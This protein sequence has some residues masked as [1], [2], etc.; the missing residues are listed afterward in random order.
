MVRAFNVTCIQCN[1][2]GDFARQNKL[3]QVTRRRCAAYFQRTAPW[4]RAP[5]CVL[6]DRYSE[7]EM[8]SPPQSLR[9]LLPEYSPLVPSTI[10]R[11]RRQVQ[12][13]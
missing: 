2:Y 10:M 6:G 3:N 13:V 9:R 8:R 5:L 7:Y 4:S 12:R 1:W 11:A